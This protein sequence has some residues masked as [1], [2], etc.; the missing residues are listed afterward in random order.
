MS[1]E[2]R[3]SAETIEKWCADIER[4]AARGETLLSDSLVVLDL[5]DSRASEA[6]LREALRTCYNA[7]HDIRGWYLEDMPAEGWEKYR[8]RDRL[9]ME[10][11]MITARAALGETP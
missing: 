3:V 10:E 2:P 1:T 6:R 7:L 5:R 11:A 8:E 9:K 4:D